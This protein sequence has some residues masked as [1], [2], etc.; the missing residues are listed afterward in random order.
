LIANERMIVL[1]S[2]PLAAA[3]AA[4]TFEVARIHQFAI[5]KREGNWEI[6]KHS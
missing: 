4:H 6:L 2:Y 1:C 3:K 5:A